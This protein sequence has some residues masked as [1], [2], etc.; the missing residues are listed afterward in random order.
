[1]STVS[2][3]AMEKQEK[4]ELNLK[5]IA[6]DCSTDTILK[7]P[8]GFKISWTTMKLC[9]EN[10]KLAQVHYFSFDGIEKGSS[11]PTQ[12]WDML[13]NE[14]FQTQ[15]PLI[16]FVLRQMNIEFNSATIKKILTNQ[17]LTDE[18]PTKTMMFKDITDAFQNSES[19]TYIEHLEIEPEYQNSGLGQKLGAYIFLQIIKQQPKSIVCWWSLP[20]HDLEKKKELYS[21]YKKFGATVREDLA[22]FSWFDAKKYNKQLKSWGI[23]KPDTNIPHSKL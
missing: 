23:I 22:G 9:N 12:I 17:D 20:L 15:L 8:S 5:D 1:M 11:L 10:K 14:K 21:F 13:S 3:T 4:K 18:S 2:C 16:E 6:I 19:A 7:L